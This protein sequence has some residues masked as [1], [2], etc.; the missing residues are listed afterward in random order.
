MAMVNT[1]LKL[2]RMNC[3]LK[4]IDLARAIGVSENL[5][6]AWETN[7]ATPGPNMRY[8]IAK[9]LG[10]TPEELFKEPGMSENKVKEAM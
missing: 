5:I 8:K 4:Q 6:S 2:A 3:S 7:R 9:I 1:A 10:V